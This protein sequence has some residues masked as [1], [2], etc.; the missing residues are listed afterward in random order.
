LTALLALTRAGIEAHLFEQ[1][2]ELKEVGAGIG[3]SA[4]ATKVLRALG[5][6]DALR[7]RGFEPRASIGRDWRTGRTQFR[8]PLM[9]AQSARFG[10]P[11]LNIHRADLLA[12]LAAAVPATRIHLGNRCVG[13]SSSDQR[14]VVTFQNGTQAEVDLVVGCDGIRSLVRNCIHG[15]DAPRF[16][17]NMCWR[18]LIPAER[19]PPNHVAPNVTVWMGPQ[20]HV[21]T[22][23][24][25]AG[26]LVNIVA[27]K[28]T[29]EWVEESWI[30]KGSRAEFTAA[31]ADVHRDLRVLI[32]RVDECFKWGLFDRDPLPT[33][34]A[35]RITLLGDAAHSMLPFLGQGA[36]MAMEDAFVLANAISRWPDDIVTA[37]NT[38]ESIRRPRTTKVQLASRRQAQIF[39]GEPSASV[40]LD[41]DWIYNHD[42]TDQT[43]IRF[44]SEL[45]TGLVGTSNRWH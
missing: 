18:A 36:A 40:S 22:Y 37:L 45:A 26:Q 4:N 30:T 35:Q 38:Y 43:S 29:P 15:A 31:Y 14:A 17:G 32:D 34:S 12:I 42:A 5:L 20:G 25:R 16:T 11:H 27:V 39:H 3:L 9:E 10:A 8:V 23:Y 19:L 21:I 44:L 24:V 2:D 41:A 28:E 33:W 6:E 7:E 13:V 1:A